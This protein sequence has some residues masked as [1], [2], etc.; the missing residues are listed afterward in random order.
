M[1]SVTEAVREISQ[2][3]SQM[4]DAADFVDSP[5]HISEASRRALAN[6]RM[7]SPSLPAMA[8]PV[9]V[10]ARAVRALANSLATQLSLDVGDEP[11]LM[12]QRPQAHPHVPETPAMLRRQEA[13]S[14]G[15][16]VPE[17]PEAQWPNQYTIRRHF[18]AA[19]AERDAQQQMQQ[20]RILRALVQLSKSRATL[21]D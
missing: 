7:Q 1:M 5:D 14:L 8:S 11:S 20:V 21:P 4:L 16:H 17:T 10:S 19:A 18:L 3:V 2:R 9:A 15:S 12:A 13:L 6:T